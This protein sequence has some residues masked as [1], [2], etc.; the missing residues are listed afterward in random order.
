M[1]LK[2]YEIR[3]LGWT[4]PGYFQ[5]YGT[6]FT[7]FTDCFVGIGANAKE[8]YEDAVE[9]ACMSLPSEL[10]L[11]KKLPTRPRGINAKHKVPAHAKEA[12]WYVALLLE[13]EE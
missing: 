4:Y 3:S 7:R 5:G 1:R 6:S 11:P 10:D 12:Y 9:Q 2:S 8:A 13:I